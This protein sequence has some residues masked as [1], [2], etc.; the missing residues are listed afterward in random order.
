MWNVASP[1]DCSGMIGIIGEVVSLQGNSSNCWFFPHCALS[2]APAGDSLKL[3]MFEQ[4]PP[5]QAVQSHACRGPGSQVRQAGS[6]TRQPS[7]KIQMLQHRAASIGTV[8]V[9]IHR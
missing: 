4:S 9:Y 2:S 7:A 8:C 5:V 3:G 6:Y 1:C